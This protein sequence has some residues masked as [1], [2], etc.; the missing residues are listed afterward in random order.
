LTKPKPPQAKPKLGLPGQAGPEKHYTQNNYQHTMAPSNK[1]KKQ[2]KAKTAAS[3][4]ANTRA[5]DG[6]NHMD[7]PSNDISVKLNGTFHY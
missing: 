5:L 2:A 4:L 7:S 3:P 6:N 1:P